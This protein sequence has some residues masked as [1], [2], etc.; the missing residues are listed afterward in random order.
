MERLRGV[1][2]RLITA[3][4]HRSKRGNMF[5]FQHKNRFRVVCRAG[6]LALCAATLC[7]S[8]FASTAAEQMARFAA[9]SGQAPQSARGQAF[10]TSTHGQEWSCSTCHTANPV[11]DGKHAKTAKVIAPMAPAVN[12]QRFSDEAKSDKWFRRNCNDVVGRECSAAEKADIIA[13]LLTLKR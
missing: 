1:N 2:V 7:G 13:W 12:P 6:A 4:Y 10:F 3:F 5:N 9:Q 8:A 11:V